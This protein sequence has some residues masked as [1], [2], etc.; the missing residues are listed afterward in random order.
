MT[1]TP[2]VSVIVPNRNH[3]HFLSRCL[4][5]IRAQTYTTLEV[6]VV[7]GASTDSSLAIAASYAKA[8]VNFRYRSEPDDGP[9]DAINKG[10]QHTSGAFLTWL[11]ADDALEPHAIERAVAAFTNN[12][13]LSL[14]YGSVL[15]VSAQGTIIRLNKGLKRDASDLAVYDFIPQAGSVFRRYDGLQLNKTLQWGFDWELWIDLAKR[16]PILNI[17]HIVAQCIVDGNTTRKS[18]MIT[19]QRTLE[20]ARI[21]RNHSPG[22]NHRVAL[23]YGT[24]MLGYALR[25]LRRIDRHYYRKIVRCAGWI[26]RIIAGRTEKGIML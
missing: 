19:P 20:L 8:F 24:A 4:D 15:D 18:D 17:D 21:A 13:P 25:P 16:G 11:N 14:V 26:H 22:L 12:P 3:G 10:I 7:D 9:A 6:I 2:T 23:G 1:P 5:S